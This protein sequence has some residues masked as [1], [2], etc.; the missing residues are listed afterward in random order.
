MENK[1]NTK[2]LSKEERKAS[3]QQKVRPNQKK[4]SI[5]LK[6]QSNFFHCFSDG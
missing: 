1:E 3:R 4:P 6:F 5:N 2:K